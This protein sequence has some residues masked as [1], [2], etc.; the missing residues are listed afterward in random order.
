VVNSKL[1]WNKQWNNNISGI[2]NQSDLEQ[3]IENDY[4]LKQSVGDFVS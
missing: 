4:T 3:L 2:S 1:R